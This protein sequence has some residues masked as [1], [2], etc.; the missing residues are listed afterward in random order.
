MRFG[1]SLRMRLLTGTL[2]VVAVFWMA[3][4]LVAWNEALNE[5]ARLLDAHLA[6]TGTLLAALAGHETREMEAHLPDPPDGSPVAFQIWESGSHLVMRSARAPDKRLSPVERGFSDQGDWRVYSLWDDEDHNLVQVAELQVSRVEMSRKL[7]VHLLIPIA[8]ALP[9]LGIALVLLVRSALAPLSSLADSI[10]SRSPEFLDQIPVD[11]APSEMLPIL[12]QLNSLLSRVGTSLSQ[13]RR[14]TADAAHELR[15]PL[16]A[17]RTHAQ[18]ARASRTDGERDTALANLIAATDR[19][20]HLIQQ[21]LTLARLDAASLAEHFCSCDLHA[22]AADLLAQG[23][24]AAVDKSIDVELAEGPPVHIVSEPT[25]L[26]VLLRNLVDN[27]VRYTPP[28]GAVKVITESSG[29]GATLEVIDNGPGIAPEDRARV[30]DRFFRLAGN[31]ETGSGLGLA[32]VAR[33]CEILGA[34]LELT[35]TPDRIGLRVRVSFPATRTSL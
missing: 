2:A 22:L 27:A 8:V 3:L 4:S 18:V 28:G 10:G 21:L 25:L 11:D 24:A 7:A 35:D 32:I 16:A 19:G 31:H 6:Q 14:F 34:R 15:T 33:I 1:G 23:M 30:L 5:T 20:A 13:E 17:M 26:S 29:G 12:D 9:L